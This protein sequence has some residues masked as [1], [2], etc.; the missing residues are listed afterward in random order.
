MYIN[1]GARIDVRDS[2]GNTALH[3]AAKYCHLELCKFLVTQRVPVPTR[4]SNN[5]TA[6]DVTDNHVI[7]QYLLPLQFQS[8]QQ[9]QPAMDNGYSNNS[10]SQYNIPHQQP[11]GGYPPAP[12]PLRQ[13]GGTERRIPSAQTSASAQPVPTANFPGAS[14]LFGARPPEPLQLSMNNNTTSNNNINNSNRP[15]TPPTFTVPTPPP[16]GMGPPH[17]AA[18]GLGFQQGSTIPA[19]PVSAPSQSEAVYSSPAPPV[20]PSYTPTAYMQSTANTNT[21]II[22]PGM[23]SSIIIIIIIHES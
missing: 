2:Q 11:I 16:V 15:D 14:H 7:R 21:R 13:S 1:K 10:M 18:A 19:V 12:S 9:Q 8:E 5:Q 3:Y 20:V 4:N 23:S 22:Q 6:Y 17:I